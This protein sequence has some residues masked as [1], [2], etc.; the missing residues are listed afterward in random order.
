M[1]NPIPPEDPEP[2]PID[3]DK[4]YC[5]QADTYLPGNPP[6]SCAGD[7]IGRYTCCQIGSFIISWIYYGLDCMDYYKIC[8]KSVTAS[9]RYLGIIDEYDSEEICKN[10]CEET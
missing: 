8:P 4:W 1:G 9:Q 10:F 6:D 7:Y 2:E 3:P 5:I